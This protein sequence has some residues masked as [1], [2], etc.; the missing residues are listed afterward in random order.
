[1]YGKKRYGRKRPARKG[2]SKL[3]K[4][5]ATAITTLAK[6]VKALQLKNKREKIVLNYQTSYNSGVSGDVE[7]FP[8]SRISAT[9]NRIFGAGANDETANAMIHKSIGLDMYLSLENTVN[10]PDTTQFTMFLVSLKDE[11][12]DQLNLTTGNITLSNGFHYTINGGLVMIN[13]KCFNIHGIKR[14]V[15]TNHGTALSA[16]SAQTQSGTDFRCYMKVRPNARVNS[17]YGDWKQLNCPADPSKN[18]FLL[19][20]NDNSVLDL[21]NPNIRINVVHTVEQLA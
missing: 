14:K 2:V 11:F 9:W 7:I 17:P 13:K 1:M 10:E 21:Q 20:F 19:V 15:L 8:L 3:L 16:P 4:K 6:A 18:Y 5:P 12:G